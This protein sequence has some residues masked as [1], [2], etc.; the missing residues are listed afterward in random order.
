MAAALTSHVDRLFSSE[1]G[2]ASGSKSN[3]R[4]DQTNLSHNEPP[5]ERRGEEQQKGA[6]EETERHN[7]S[8]QNNKVQQATQF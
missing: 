8:R 6:A 4:T 5:G 2:D 3:E 1:S 7:Q